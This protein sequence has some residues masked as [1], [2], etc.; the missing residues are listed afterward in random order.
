MSGTVSTASLRALFKCP[1]QG[2]RWQSRFLVG[3][4]LFLAN[5][6]IPTVPSI[7]VGGYLV[8]VM[9]QTLDA[10][11]PDLPAWDDWGRLAKDGLGVIVVNLI[12]FFPG[13]LILLGRMAV[14]LWATLYL[15]LSAATAAEPP[16]QMT[17]LP[18]MIL[19]S[20]AVLLG[21]MFLGTL[22]SLLAAAGHP[23]LRDYNG[24]CHP[25]AL[26]PAAAPGDPCRFLQLP[27]LGGPLWRDLAPGHRHSCRP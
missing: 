8:R 1:L 22:L 27:A 21:S 25:R 12:Y 4:A 19:G 26:L 15:P 7:F 24:L 6:L 20:I 5:Y 23:L 2:P 9:R 17:T 13:V 14:Y 16:E 3:C 11:E 10:G 18:M